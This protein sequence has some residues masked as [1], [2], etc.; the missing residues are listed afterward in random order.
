MF[1]S[2]KIFNKNEDVAYLI[3]NEVSE[4]EGEESSAS[5]EYIDSQEN[6]QDSENIDQKNSEETSETT[7]E[8]IV[9]NK[10]GPALGS[11]GVQENVAS[12]AEMAYY[13]MLSEIVSDMY[14]YSS[15]YCM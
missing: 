4:T 8:E 12:E 13:D 2:G 11:F 9:G 5:E 7:T 14:K 1:K 6:M 3:E 10:T 15:D